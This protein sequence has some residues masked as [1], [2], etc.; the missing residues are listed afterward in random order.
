[1]PKA[2]FARADRNQAAVVKALRKA[3]YHV[4][5]TYTVGKGFPDLAVSKNGLTVLLEVKDGSKAPSARRLT[6]DELSFFAECDGAVYKVETGEHAIRVMEKH[7]AMT[8]EERKIECRN[9]RDR[10]LA[11]LMRAA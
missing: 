8:D 6:G 11:L 9:R 10:V 2:I 5:H 7:L 4:A 1:M 3:G